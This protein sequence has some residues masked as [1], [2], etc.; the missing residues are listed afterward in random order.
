MMHIIN[1]N[2][3]KRRK[4]FGFGTVIVKINF[5]GHVYIHQMVLILSEIGILHKLF[6]IFLISSF[7]ELVLLYIMKMG[8]LLI[9]EID[10]L[11]CG[12]FEGFVTSD[13]D[14]CNVITVLRRFF[15]MYETGNSVFK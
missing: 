9:D 2:G 3:Y 13:V 15:S 11:P 1:V 7:D 4:V 14:G 5:I 6:L 12:L 8:S 10:M